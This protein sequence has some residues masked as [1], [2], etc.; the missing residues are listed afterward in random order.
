MIDIDK[1]AEEFR[2]KHHETRMARGSFYC[3]PSSKEYLD[4]QDSGIR[5]GFKAG[6]NAVLAKLEGKE[7]AIYKLRSALIEWKNQVDNFK[8]DYLPGHYAMIA[9]AICLLYTSDAADE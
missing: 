7:K 2:Q 3:K 6:A 4:T 1:M 5:I 9:Q 8:G